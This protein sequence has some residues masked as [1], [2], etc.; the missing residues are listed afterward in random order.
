MKR[1]KLRS[2]YDSAD[3]GTASASASASASA[4]ESDNECIVPADK[5][6]VFGS[7]IDEPGFSQEERRERLNK[8]VLIRHARMAFDLA[9]D[10]DDARR[11][12]DFYSTLGV[13]LIVDSA[14]LL[15]ED[16]A[17]E[18]SASA[19]PANSHRRL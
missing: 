1:H 2:A 8:E 5:I 3:A 10:A 16:K 17:V 19:P 14:E 4:F 12:V 18:R 7:D 11:I 6:D 13:E 15:D 9:K